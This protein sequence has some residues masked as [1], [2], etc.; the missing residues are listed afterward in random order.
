MSQGLLPNAASGESR[1]RRRFLRNER[2]VWT[3]DVLVASSRDRVLRSLPAHPRGTSIIRVPAEISRDQ[4]R[5]FDSP[6]N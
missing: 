6:L 1:A 3:R 5:D 2:Q 4:F